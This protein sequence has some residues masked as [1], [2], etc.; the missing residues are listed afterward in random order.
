MQ[1]FSIECRY[2]KKRKKK[3]TIDIIDDLEFSSDD[4]NKE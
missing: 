3:M 2:T 1:V 4:S